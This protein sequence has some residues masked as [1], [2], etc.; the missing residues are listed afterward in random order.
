MYAFLRDSVA[1]VVLLCAAYA[2]ESRQPGGGRFVPDRADWAPFIGVGVLG[3]W[4]AQAMSALAIANLTP[5]FFSFAAP[6]YPV[7]ALA[8]ALTLGE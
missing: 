2:Y 5:T 4:G 3:I 7:V 8:L 1:S 6:L